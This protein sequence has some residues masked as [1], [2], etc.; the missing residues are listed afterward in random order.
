MDADCESRIALV[1][2]GASGIGYG[3]AEALLAR[4]AR[5]AIGDINPQAL[6]RAAAT[7][8]NANLLPLSLDVTSSASVRQAVE[9]CIESF[10]GLDTL[11][12]SAGIIEFAPVGEILE[13]HWQHIVAVNLTGVFLCC[14]ASAPF[15]CQSGRGRIVTLSS[16]AGK[17]GVALISSYCATKFGVIGFSKALAAELAPHGVTVN[18]VC[19]GGVTET[20]MGDQVLKWLSA[21]LGKSQEEILAERAKSVPLGR[22]QT[23][24]DVVGTVMFLISDAASYITAEALNVDG[25]GLG[26]SRIRGL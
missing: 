26:T 20:Q 25:G 9:N 7:L 14:Q 16:D 2:G 15:L 11:V 19:P 23:T 10:G 18:C 6:S 1:S 8:N 12:N 17:I 5:V 22:M 4:G 3:V 21:K 13:E 24:N